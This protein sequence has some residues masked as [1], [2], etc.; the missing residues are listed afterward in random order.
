MSSQDQVILAGYTYKHNKACLVCEHIFDGTEPIKI[1][2]HDEDGLLQFLCGAHDHD[3]SK[4]KVVAISS[5][6][7]KLPGELE[8]PL[9]KPGF[10]A[11]LI[12][13]DSE[14]SYFVQKIPE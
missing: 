14:K 10:F 13:K 6:A 2:V 4:A 11:E 9:L 8:L 7:K 5:Q 3:H 12:E 1:I